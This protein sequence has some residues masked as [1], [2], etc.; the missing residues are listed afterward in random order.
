M[1]D[2]DTFHIRATYSHNNYAIIEAEFDENAA[3][4]RTL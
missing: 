1:Q 3:L 4:F 2:S